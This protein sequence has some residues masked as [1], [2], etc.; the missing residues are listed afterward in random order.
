MKYNV[1]RI[2]HLEARP[3][4]VK[5]THLQIYNK[6]TAIFTKLYCLFRKKKLNLNV[7]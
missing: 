7:N 5:T 6:K 1:T 4:T 2:L 3:I